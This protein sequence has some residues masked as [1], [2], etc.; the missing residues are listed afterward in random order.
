M[1]R[2]VSVVGGGGSGLS[3][4][5]FLEDNPDFELHLFERERR[6]GGHAITAE[7]PDIGTRGGRFDPIVY[8]FFKPIYPLFSSWLGTLGIE[9]A[10]LDFVSYL[11]NESTRKA[12]R[13]TPSLRDIVTAANPFADVRRK[14][15]LRSLFETILRLREENELDP[16]MSISEL[17][18]K[19][20]ELDGDV[21]NELLVPLLCWSLHAREDQIAD[22][23]C[24]EFL[25][26]LADVYKTP[27]TAFVIKDGVQSYIDTVASRLSRTVIHRESSVVRIDRRDGQW[28]VFDKNGS[29]IQSDD[30]VLAIWPKQIV[31]LIDA[32]KNAGCFAQPDAAAH[33]DT[34]REIMASIEAAHIRAVIHQDQTFMPARRSQ[35]SSYVIVSSKHYPNTRPTVW[36]G[37]K[38]QEPVFTSFDWSENPDT[39]KDPSTWTPHEGPSLFTAYPMRA[40]PRVNLHRARKQIKALQGQSRLWFTGAY[41]RHVGYHEHAVRNSLSILT[42]LDKDYRHLP[43]LSQVATGAYPTDTWDRLQSAVA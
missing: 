43:R 13:C 11:E 34:I 27:H 24:A 40:P 19:F 9:T 42:R 35:W 18:R 10:P 21:V 2:K 8:L 7:L 6:L 28:F 12:I 32:S 38:D 36:S 39:V 26:I 15:Q 17:V 29:E 31:D 33:A 22:C 5:Y 20:P 4:C 16:D 23:P 25:E 41:L 3:L 14:L 1:P 30:L 37:E